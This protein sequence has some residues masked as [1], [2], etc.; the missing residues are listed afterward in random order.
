MTRSS[1][2]GGRFEDPIGV[3]DVGDLVMRVMKHEQCLPEVVTHIVET[4][5]FQVVEE[6]L[7]DSECRSL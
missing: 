5:F 7:P 4:V 6:L 1:S 3:V 2:D